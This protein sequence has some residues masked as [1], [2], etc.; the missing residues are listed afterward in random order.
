M[1]PALSSTRTYSVRILRTLAALCAEFVLPASARTA[2]GQP[3][4]LFHV[5]LR[6]TGMLRSRRRLPQCFDEFLGFSQIAG[7]EPLGEPIIDRYKK[8]AGLLAFTSI[9]PQRRQ[10]RCR[11]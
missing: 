10:A 3:G 4:A 8:L 5:P 1:T 6:T 2:S 11:A 9:A 7:V